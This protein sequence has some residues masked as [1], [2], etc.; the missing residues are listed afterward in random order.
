MT[1]DEE[2]LLSGALTD[3]VN[4]AA[5]SEEGSPGGSFFVP[6]KKEKSGAGEGLVVAGT[7]SGRFKYFLTGVCLSTVHSLKYH[8]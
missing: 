2:I 7:I 4:L 1:A 8:C 5:P 3:S 6:P